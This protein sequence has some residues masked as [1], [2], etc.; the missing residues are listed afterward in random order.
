MTKHFLKKYSVLK[1]ENRNVTV[2]NCR[3]T[4]TDK[5]LL[6]GWLV[7]K[8][9]TTHEIKISSYIYILHHDHK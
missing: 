9:L 5:S 6:F 8:N 7:D 2:E 1:S 4:T 3:V